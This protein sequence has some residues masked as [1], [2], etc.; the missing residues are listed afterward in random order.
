M[1]ELYTLHDNKY[2][3][4]TQ[5]KK[6]YIDTDFFVNKFWIPSLKEL[7]IDYRRPYNTHH[8]HATNMLYNNL[9]TPVQLA[10]L[11]GHANT[12][13]VFDVYVNYLDTFNNNFDR[14]IKIYK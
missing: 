8:T 1:Q 4:I 7:N 6:P 2:L 10:Q 13:M 14:S 9:V 5:Y 11:L 3:F 12:Q